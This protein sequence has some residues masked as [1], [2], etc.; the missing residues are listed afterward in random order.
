MFNDS[1]RPIAWGE[2]RSTVVER[3]DEMKKKYYVT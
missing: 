2:P 3:E 1:R